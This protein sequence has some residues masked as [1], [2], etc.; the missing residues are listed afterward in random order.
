[1]YVP[2]IAACAVMSAYLMW[3]AYTSKP[4]R[5]VLG[6]ISLILAGLPLGMFIPDL[7]FFT[8]I[9]D[10]LAW[11]KLFV[12]IVGLLEMILIPALGLLKVKQTDKFDVPTDISSG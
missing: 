8:E 5:E 12:C 1:M 7:I 4:D 11:I 10:K 2:F 9:W 3:G 6:W